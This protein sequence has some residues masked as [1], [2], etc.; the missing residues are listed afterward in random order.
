M[1]RESYDDMTEITTGS[2][3]KGSTKLLIVTIFLALLV[4]MVSI[5]IWVSVSKEEQR[6]TKIQ[7]QEQYE[8]NPIIPKENAVKLVI[9]HTDDSEDVE[10]LVVDNN[11]TVDTTV[12][13]QSDDIDPSNIASSLDDV[14]FD[15]DKIVKYVEHEVTEGENLVSISEFYGLRVQTLV[16]VNSITN[17]L[18][19]KSGTIISIPDRDGSIYVVQEGDVLSSVVKKL[20]L[21]MNWKEL[22]DLNGISGNLTTGQRIFI[23]DIVTET[24]PEAALFINPLPDGEIVG[25]Y[26]QVI[27]DSQSGEKTVLDGIQIQVSSTTNVLASAAGTVVQKGVNSDGKGKYLML[28]HPEGYTTYYLGLTDINVD[29]SD[30]VEQEDIIGTNDDVLFFRIEQE[31]ISLNPVVFFNSV[32]K[33]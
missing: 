4:C 1:G 16:S 26:N 17:P 21:E 24:E 22:Q 18:D 11:E 9:N 3:K 13:E 33:N 14:S 30:K 31:G 19:M 12:T 7:S 2:S 32:N 28:T 23:P 5:L 10:N 15:Q 8:E 20:N 6:S 29:L 27:K 25:L